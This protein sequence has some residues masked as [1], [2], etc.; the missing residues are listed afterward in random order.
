MVWLQL[1]ITVLHVCFMC[2]N[3]R[4]FTK[5]WQTS[6]EITRH[7]TFSVCGPSPRRPK[8]CTLKYLGRRHDVLIIWHHT[9]GP[10]TGGTLLPVVKGLRNVPIIQL[11][12][13]FKS[14]ITTD[15]LVHLWLLLVSHMFSTAPLHHWLEDHQDWVHLAKLGWKEELCEFA[16]QGSICLKQAR[17]LLCNILE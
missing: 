2:Y 12:N 6:P 4:Q 8:W 9:I 10:S 11:I 15:I 3:L 13:L 7:L 17:L 14:W 16:G 5:L 1:L